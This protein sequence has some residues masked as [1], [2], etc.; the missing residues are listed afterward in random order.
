MDK[1]KDGTFAHLRQSCGRTARSKLDVEKRIKIAITTWLTHFS[2]LLPKIKRKSSIFLHLQ[3]RKQ[4][5]K[6]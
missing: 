5:L 2:F 6:D 1:C 4:L 3:S